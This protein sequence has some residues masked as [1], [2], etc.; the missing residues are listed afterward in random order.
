L[1][2]GKMEVLRVRFQFE[3]ASDPIETE[4]RLDELTLVD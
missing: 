4:V 2:V 3:G 1:G